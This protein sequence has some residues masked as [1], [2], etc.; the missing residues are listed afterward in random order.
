MEQS[1]AKTGEETDRG[2]GYSVA[3]GVGFV[4]SG[5]L[6][7]WAPG[8]MPRAL[9]DGTGYIL[10]KGADVILQL[11][12]NRTGRLEKDRTTVG[13]Y[14]ARKP[15]QRRYQSLVLQGLFLG[16]KIPA[17][18]DRYRV[19][20]GITVRQDCEIHSVIPHMHTLGREVKITMT[21]P[22]EPPRTLVAITD[23]AYHW[24]ES[25]FF[26]Q[27]IPVPAG[28]RFEIE[29]IYDNSAKNA[30]NPNQPPRDVY[31]GTQTTNEMCYGFIGAT[32]AKPGRIPV[33]RK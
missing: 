8:Q 29:A 30:D 13:L 14:L 4:P 31:F 18:Q 11:H 5:G 16:D 19:R 3:M 17:G 2:P 6:G 21:P 24:Q 27:P 26:Q 10:P 7:G 33:E 20:S 12:Y 32:T 9:P 25:Y 28:T 22:S 15:V 1:R 23:W